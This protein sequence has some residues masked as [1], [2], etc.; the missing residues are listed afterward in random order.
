MELARD[1]RTDLAEFLATLTPEQ[2]QTESLC[3]GWT[4]KDVVAHVVSY[5][6]LKSRRITQAFRQGAGGACQRSRVAEYL[7]T[8]AEPSQ[9]CGARGRWGGRSPAIVRAHDGA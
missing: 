8:D 5:E 1:E 6:E 7:T 4:V 3:A 9:R 2:W